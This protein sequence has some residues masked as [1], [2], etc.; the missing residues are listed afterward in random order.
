MVGTP[1]YS[2]KYSHSVNNSNSRS[3]N[4]NSSRNNSNSSKMV[5]LSGYFINYVLFYILNLLITSLQQVHR[6]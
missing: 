2:H 6:Y 1:N 5:L 3:N 4:N